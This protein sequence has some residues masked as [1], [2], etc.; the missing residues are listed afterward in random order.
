MRNRHPQSG[1][2]LIELLVVIAIIGILAGVVLAS[3]S[4]ARR[5]SQDA[6]IKQS[7][8]NLAQIAEQ[9]YNEVGDYREL[10][11]WW[12]GTSGGTVQTCDDRNIDGLITSS[13]GDN[14]QELCESIY[15]NMPLQTN[16]YM[17]WGYRERVG[18][19]SYAWQNDGYAFLVR[20]N[21]GNWYC[22]NN[23]GAVQESSSINTAVAGCRDVT[24]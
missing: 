2:T 15:A 17:Y 16:Y 14:F 19:G 22:V 6:A 3:I 21:S 4:D 20:L 24:L 1:F 11:L 8:R 5:E 18:A 23:F 7:M 9:H 10:R 12:M 13:Y